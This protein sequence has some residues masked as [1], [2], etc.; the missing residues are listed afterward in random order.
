MR[1]NGNGRTARPTVSGNSYPP[2]PKRAVTRVVCPLPPPPPPPAY[3][4][5]STATRVN[6][7]SRPQV[8]HRLVCPGAPPTT[9]LIHRGMPPSHEQHHLCQCNQGVLAAPSRVQGLA[10]PVPQAVVG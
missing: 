3:V 1:A 5:S 7:P 4:D 9:Q 8:G 2:P 10:T 6:N